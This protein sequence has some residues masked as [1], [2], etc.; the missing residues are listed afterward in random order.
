M[1]AE[2]GMCI[3]A[4]GVGVEN[5][6]C[7]FSNH[8]LRAKKKILTSTITISLTERIALFR[9]LVSRQCWEGA[10]KHRPVLGKEAGRKGPQSRPGLG[11]AGR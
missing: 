3:S 10:A 1:F 7:L 9:V 11:R 5:A 4:W 6:K 8:P 2:L